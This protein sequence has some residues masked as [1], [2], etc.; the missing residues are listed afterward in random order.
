[1]PTS[2]RI[3]QRRRWDGTPYGCP[4]GMTL[5]ELLIA[6]AIGALIFT[7]VFSVTVTVST[8]LQ[9]QE[10]WRL[11]HTPAA[12]AVD[13]LTRDLFC[14]AIPAYATQD[15]FVLKQEPIGSNGMASLQLFSAVEDSASTHIRAYDIRHITYSVQ[16][17]RGGQLSLIRLE[18]SLSTPGATGQ[19][20][21]LADD[22]GEFH[23]SVFDGAAW[24]NGWRANAGSPLPC[25]ARIALRSQTDSRVC[26]TEILIPAG[27]RIVA[28]NFTGGSR[29]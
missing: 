3:P 11:I 19:V 14:A 26:S 2:T 28:T 25:A 13:G 12:A 1:M 15:V 9:R 5:I 23:I 24:T 7:V 8:T 17:N 6:L 10:D 4:G 27:L 16:T 20:E 18:T 22:I 21:S 29:P